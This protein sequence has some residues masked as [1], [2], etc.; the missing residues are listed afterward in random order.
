[1][2]LDKLENNK[3]IGILGGTFDPA[4]KGHVVISKIAK[5]KFKLSKV[6]WAITK[7][8]PFK[9]SSSLNL[10]KRIKFA[11]KINLKNKFIEVAFY[12]KKIKSNKTVDLIKFFKKKKFEIYFIMGADNLISFHK[13]KDSNQILKLC[14]ILVF[15]RDG[16]KSKSLKSP[17]YT[18]YNKKNIE[19]IKFDKVN[20][21]SS[22][23]RKI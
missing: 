16:Y 5:K 6:I 11:K 14:R 13:W 19:F 1:M 15:D 22:Q 21:S 3:K 20:I 4:H 23:L 12:E 2:A 7:R 17:T 9:E 18:R 10:E 8:N